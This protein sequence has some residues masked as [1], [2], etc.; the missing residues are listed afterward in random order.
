[1]ENIRIYTA[2]KYW[3]QIFTDLGMTVVDSPNIA[4]VVFNDI[5]IEKP[6]SINVLKKIV[7]NG[8]D[9]TDIIYKIFGSDVGLSNLQRKLVVLLYKNPNIMMRDL[10][11]ALGMSPD[12]TTHAVE[13]AIYQL[14][15]KYGHDFILNT[16][17]KYKIG[18]L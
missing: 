15:K 9:N 10:K 14:R 8:T 1:M 18:K 7:L 6:V 3:N 5:D 13:T 4:D 11:I 2:D 17:G 16:N 12:I